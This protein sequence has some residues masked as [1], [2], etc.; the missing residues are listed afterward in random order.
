MSDLYPDNESERIGSVALPSQ[1]DVDYHNQVPRMTEDEAALVV[2]A[3]QQT[4]VRLRRALSMA[5]RSTYLH[6]LETYD[7]WIV[8]ATRL[9][10]QL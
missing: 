4:R 6:N 7:K 2:A 9:R 5:N 8:E 1:A 3:D 10:S